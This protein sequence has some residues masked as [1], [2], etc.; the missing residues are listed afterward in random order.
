MAMSKPPSAAC[1]NKTGSPLPTP[2]ADKRTS[3]R[4][5]LVAGGRG[6]K[7]QMRLVVRRS[8]LIDQQQAELWP[9][10]RYHA[11]ITNRTDLDTTAADAYHR[12][13]ATVE[14]AI[15]DL[16][17]STGL[18]HCSGSEIVSVLGGLITQRW[19]CENG[20]VKGVSN[21]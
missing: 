18:A 19:G 2:P 14:L 10:W 21:D 16:K 5:P 6:D 11:F 4:P 15:R 3:R 17:E 13:H 1:A 7:R 20:A 8:R 9:D 12:A